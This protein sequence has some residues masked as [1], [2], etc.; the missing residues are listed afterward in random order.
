MRRVCVRVPK[1][2]RSSA[3]EAW[4]AEVSEPKPGGIDVH[5]I[6]GQRHTRLGINDARDFPAS[7]QMSSKATLQSVKGE[8]VDVTAGERVS[9]IKVGG[10]IFCPDVIDALW[11]GVLAWSIGQGMRPSVVEHPPL[12]FRRFASATEPEVHDNSI[13]SWWNP[14]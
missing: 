1:L 5:A 6:D 12:C 7:K 2:L 3:V 11:R 13:G 8:A 9:S 4:A 14:R 10:A